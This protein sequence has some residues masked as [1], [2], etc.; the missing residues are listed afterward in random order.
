MSKREQPRWLGFV[1]KTNI[2]LTESQK[3]FSEKILNNKIIFGTGPAGTS[4]TFTACYSAI[5]AMK[6]N[7]FKQIVICKPIEEAGEKLGFLPG[8][9][10][11][12]IAPY[13]QSFYS[14]FTKIIGL[15]AFSLLKGDMILQEKPLAYMR[16]DSFEDSIMILDEA[17]NC[18]FRQLMLFVTRMGKGSKVII[19]GD[20]SQYDIMLKLVSLP[21]F[22][23]LI[24]DVKGVTSHEF[25]EDDIVRD[26]IL[27]EIAKRYE[28]FKANNEIINKKR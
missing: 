13:F 1:D 26:P 5:E 27:I 10:E 19:T 22:I 7:K 14:S 21:Q 28:E 6:T 8:D 23:E 4:K 12:K 9:K 17:Q 18:D 11:D 15:Q 24:S 25:S 16:G 20:I 3:E 2:E